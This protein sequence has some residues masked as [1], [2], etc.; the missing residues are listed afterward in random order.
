MR[1][2]TDEI[3]LLR[4]ESSTLIYEA[5]D[6]KIKNLVIRTLKEKKLIL[7]GLDCHF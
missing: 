4:K 3:K 1:E 2:K 7:K 5:F 6:L